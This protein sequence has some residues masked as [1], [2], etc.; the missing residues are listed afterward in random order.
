ME[1]A[2]SLI[3][4]FL[5]VVSWGTV[6]CYWGLCKLEKYKKARRQGKLKDSNP[7]GFV[8]LNDHTRL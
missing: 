4:T 6:L 3:I 2:D 5:A 1:Q 8:A 7:L